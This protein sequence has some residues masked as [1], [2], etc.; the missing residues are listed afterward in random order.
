MGHGAGWTGAGGCG[1]EGFQGLGLGWWVA[2]RTVTAE[3]L[4]VELGDEAVVQSILDEKCVVLRPAR[5]EVADP[6]ALPTRAPT[7]EA[8]A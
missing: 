6:P 3:R 2:W 1:R 4:P 7:A 8:L 5:A